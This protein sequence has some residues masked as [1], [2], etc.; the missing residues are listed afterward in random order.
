MTGNIEYNKSKLT[1]IENYVIA[2]PELKGYCSYIKIDK[3]LN[4]VY[5][6][7]STVK[8]FIEYTNKNQSEI[9]MSDFV[10]FIS[11]KSIKSDGSE[12]TSSFMVQ[13]YHALKS[14]STYLFDNGIISKNYM[15]FVKRPKSIESQ[16]TIEKREKGYLD[17]TE[18]KLYMKAVKEG[19]GSSHARQCQRKTKERDYAIIMIFLTTG[20]RC[21]ALIKLDI[22]DIDFENKTLMVTDKGRQV[23]SYQLNDMTIEAINEWLAARPRFIVDDSPALFL[24]KY[25]HRMQRDGIVGITTKYAVNIKGKNITP[26]KLRATYG[27]QL[28]EATKD[29]YFVQK[30][31]GHSGPSVTERYIRGQKGITKTASDIMSKLI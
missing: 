7:L 3:S 12:V 25:G 17:K 24:N 13:M 22:T 30:A 31:M 18:L 5:N 19:V 23:H 8:T 28:Y 26:H 2:H 27:T 16:E 29:I 4:T 10:N 14:Y 11:E 9:T 1:L 6:Y 20:I 21:S 15:L